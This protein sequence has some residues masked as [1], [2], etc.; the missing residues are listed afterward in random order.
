MGAQFVDSFD[1]YVTAQIADKWS[2]SIGGSGNI[3]SAGGSIIESGSGREGTKC[4]KVTQS[5]IVFNGVYKALP[6]NASDR[7]SVV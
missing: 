3:I 6:D 4:M 2:A 5:S 1:H 7:K